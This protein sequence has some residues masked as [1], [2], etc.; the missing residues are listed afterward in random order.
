MQWKF[1]TDIELPISIEITSY[2]PGCEGSPKTGPPRSYQDIQPPE[3]EECEFK[4]LING[5]EVD[6]PQ[7]LYNELYEEILEKAR[8]FKQDEKDYYMELKAEAQAE[9]RMEV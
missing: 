6:L 3:P 5:T 9:K 7:D 2:N 8:E 1:Q 4:T